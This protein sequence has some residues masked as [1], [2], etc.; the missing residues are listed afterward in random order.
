ML[1]CCS[2]ILRIIRCSKSLHLSFAWIVHF[3]HWSSISQNPVDIWTILSGVFTGGETF[4]VASSGKYGLQFN[5]K[6][7]MMCHNGSVIAFKTHDKPSYHQYKKSVVIIRN[8]YQAFIADF[9]RSRNSHYPSHYE[10][11]HVD[12][13]LEK[14]FF[15]PGEMFDVI[16][17]CKR[18]KS[19][20]INLAL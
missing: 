3:W 15:S 1:I 16:A 19:Q 8:P 18:L 9:H 17:I 4:L 5:Q 10:K 11:G 2:S 13:V 20:C 6:Y 12:V 14:S 7:Q